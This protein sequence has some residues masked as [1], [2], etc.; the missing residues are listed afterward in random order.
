MHSRGDRTSDPQR[1]EMG[2]STE[3]S[4]LVSMLF[5]TFLNSFS[6]IPE[7]FNEFL[8]YSSSQKK[9]EWLAKMTNGKCRDVIHMGNGHAVIY[10]PGLHC[11]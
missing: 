5:R 1:N 11:T 8:L 10:G 2:Q 6:D 4:P 9:S 7:I 3:R